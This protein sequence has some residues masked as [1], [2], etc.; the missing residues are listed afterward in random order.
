MD[1]MIVYPG[2]IPLDTDLLNV[3]RATMKA[4]GFLAQACLGTGTIVDGL[5]CTPTVPAS[6]TVNIGPGSI[7]QLGEVDA[8]AYGTLAPDPANLVRMGINE[9]AVSFPLTPPTVSG[10]S[11]NYLIEAAFL[12]ADGV[13]VVLPYYN[14]ADPSQGFAGAGNSG[15]AQNTQRVQSV[16]LQLRAGA[17]ANTGTQATPAADPGYV[18]IAV[19]TVNYGQATIDGNSIA[20]PGAAPFLGWKLPQLD[21]SATQTKSGWQR[22]PSGMVLQ[23]GSATMA[24]G[25]LD[26]F[27]FPLAFPNTALSVVACEGAAGG[28]NIPGSSIP[29]P[30]VYGVDSVSASGFR[31]SCVALDINGSS[32]TAVYT[33]VAGFNWFAIGF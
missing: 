25:K 2:A 23:W 10:Q 4:L 20:V 24:T 30:T 17:A 6:L 29:V 13:P 16:A 3:Q 22:L 32:S 11:I 31:A 18:P 5:A 14:P 21:F 15:N 19:I 1:R 9:S 28:W 33:K 27:S 8:E 26:P 12:E 7:T